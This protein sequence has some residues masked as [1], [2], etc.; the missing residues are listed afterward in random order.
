MVA[1]PKVRVAT[2]CSLTVALG[3]PRTAAE[4]AP[5]ARLLALA[6]VVPRGP[7]VEGGTG[8]VPRG[9]V[10][11]GGRSPRLAPTD[12]STPGDAASC[13]SPPARR[14]LSAH[15]RFQSRQREPA[16]VIEPMG[17]ALPRLALIN[18]VGRIWPRPPGPAPHQRH[19]GLPM[20]RRAAA[21]P[22]GPAGPEAGFPTQGRRGRAPAGRATGRGRRWAGAAESVRGGLRCAPGACVRRRATARVLRLPS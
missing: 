4:T 19:R 12:R 5:T 11:E 15:H 22:A 3:R 20:E 7:V 13:P 14:L 10:V 16:A 8:V 1:W 18:C 6:P 2:V 21:V 9:A 17:E